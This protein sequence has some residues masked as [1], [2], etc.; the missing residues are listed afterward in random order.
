MTQELSSLFEEI[1][2]QRKLVKMIFSA[3]RKKSLSCHKVIIR[4]VQIGENFLYQKESLHEKKAFHEGVQPRRLEKGMCQGPCR[5]AWPTP[6]AAYIADGL[7]SDKPKKSAPN[8]QEK[9]HWKGYDRLCAKARFVLTFE[10]TGPE[11]PA[12]AG[13]LRKSQAMQV[14]H[15]PSRFFDPSPS[16]SSPDR[17]FAQ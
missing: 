16:S 8:G 5:K 4:P 3:K 14:F 10:P 1:F 17:Q 13:F 6:Y 15:A 2:S 11:Y 7:C 12:R 9:G